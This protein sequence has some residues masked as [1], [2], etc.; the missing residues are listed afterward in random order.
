VKP[1]GGSKAAGEGDSFVNVDDLEG[2]TGGVHPLGD[3]DRVAIRGRVHGSL[4]GGVARAGAATVA[5]RGDVKDASLSM[6]RATIEGEQKGCQCS[7]SES[8]G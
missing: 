1:V 5:A 7:Q 4:D 6:S 2:H 8:E 3:F